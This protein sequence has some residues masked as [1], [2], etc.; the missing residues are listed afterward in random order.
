MN[1]LVLWMVMVGFCG[2]AMWSAH[3]DEGPMSL[4]DYASMAHVKDEL[5]PFRFWRGAAWKVIVGRLDIP[6]GVT[7]AARTVIYEDDSY[8]AGVYKDQ[9]LIFFAHGYEPLVITQVMPLKECVFDAGVHSFVTPSVDDIRELRGTVVARGAGKE[10]TEIRCAL[11]I[12][13]EEYIG[14]DHGYPCDANVYVTVSGQK[15]KADG[16]FEFHGLS[17]IPYWLRISSPGYIEQEIE[18]DRE[19]NGVI[20]LGD[21]VLSWSP[22][23][24]IR[25]EAR[26]RHKQGEW[27]YSPSGAE[28]SMECNGHNQ[29]RFSDERDGLGNS[30][31]LRMKPQDDG[32]KASFFFYQES[33]YDLG[34]LG[35]AAGLPAFDEVDVVGCPGRSHITLKDGHAYYFSAEDINETDIQLLFCVAEVVAE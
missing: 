34:P 5:P 35:S 17:R 19:Q 22:V 8:A 28:H 29:F 32:V 1:R 6:E 12:H 3:S 31:V 30:L 24:R 25:Y 33:F 26:V 7:V 4:P 10:A 18:I 21:V 13:N 11:E 16:G 14:T 20:D 9:P 27:L 2:M 23:Y 15:A